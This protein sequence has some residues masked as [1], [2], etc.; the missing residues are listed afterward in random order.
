MTRTTAAV[1]ALATLTL[2]DIASASAADLGAAYAEAPSWTGFHVGVQGGYRWGDVNGEARF[3]RVP[4]TPTTPV[5]TVTA[6]A[7]AFNPGSAGHSFDVDSFTGGVRLGYDYQA[8]S[9][10]VVGVLADAAWGK[11]SSSYAVSSP[12]A[13]PTLAGFDG[14]FIASGGARVKH[15]W[16][17][18]IRA[19]VGYLA[20]DSVLLYATGGLALLR[21]QVSGF[22]DNGGVSGSVSKSKTRVGWTVGGGVE[23]ALTDNWRVHAEYRYADFGSKTYGWDAA[24]MK[25]RVD[26]KTHTVLTG[27]SYR[28]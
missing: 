14:S 10:I 24:G 25:A 22:Y 8:S 17:G 23:A 5:S 15:T 21:E 18:T 7:V 26:T 20:T 2:F 13:I 16:D 6:A 28:F 12:V 19:R 3:D 1:A 11:D 4:L 27:V 9:S